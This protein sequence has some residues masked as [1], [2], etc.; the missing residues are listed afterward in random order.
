LPPTETFLPTFH[1]WTEIFMR[2]SMRN[3]VQYVKDHGLS[4]S[5]A[6]ALFHIFRKGSLGVS[7]IAEFLDISNAAASQMLERL[8]QQGL[9]LRSEDPNDRRLKQIVLTEKGCQVMHDSIQARQKWL[10]DLA[11]YMT[12]DEHQQVIAALH[13]LIAKAGQAEDAPNPPLFHKGD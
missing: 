10:E 5:Q 13:I 3:F 6:N 1:T 8:V 4:M 7:D 9:V 11:E 12:P 2:H